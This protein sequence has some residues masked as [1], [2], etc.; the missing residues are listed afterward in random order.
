MP[1]ITHIRRQN[2]LALFRQFVGG[3]MTEGASSKG[4]EQSFA[5][6]VQVSASMWSEI[7]SARP[8][9]DKLARQLEYHC[10]KPPGW[11]DESHG[12]AAP[13]NAAEERFVELAR[14]A[15]RSHTVRG[16][17]ELAIW[18]KSKLPAQQGGRS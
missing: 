10:A 9:G 3:A 1:N 11:L 5:A 8:V 16:K 15:W 13:P 2:A 18:L 14:R 17:R 6:T 12:D 4:L 7:E